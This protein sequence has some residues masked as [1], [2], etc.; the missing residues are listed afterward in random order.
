VGQTTLLEQFD[1]TA[2][3]MLASARYFIGNR[4]E[5]I[6]RRQCAENIND[7]MLLRVGDRK[8]GGSKATSWRLRELQERIGEQLYEPMTTRDLKVDG[9]DI[10]KILKIKPGPKVG[11]IL[12]KLFDEV[13]ED[14]G[15]NTREYLK[16]RVEKLGSS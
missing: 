5:D 14:T 13:M 1:G 11:K 16:K 3:Y 9:K 10:M 15:L 2:P 8:G 12:N 4:L 6:G 7:M